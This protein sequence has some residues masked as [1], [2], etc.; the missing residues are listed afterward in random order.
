MCKNTQLSTSEISA[1]QYFE[2]VGT[3]QSPSFTEHVVSP[4]GLSAGSVS[5]I[6]MTNF[7]DIDGDGDVF[8]NDLSSMFDGYSNVVTFQENISPSSVDEH[9]GV[10]FQIYPNPVSSILNI[11]F[12]EFEGHD[13]IIKIYDS[14]GKLVFEKEAILNFNLDVSAFSSGLYTVE[15]SSESG[16]CQR[17]VVIE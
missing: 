6:F 7:V 14:T 8:H 3:A 4:F 15:M 5:G 13:S 11:N 1:L 9:F 10:E 17:S 12:G 16:V 2:N